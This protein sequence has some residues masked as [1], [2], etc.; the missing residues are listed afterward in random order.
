MQTRT[1]RRRVVTL[2]LASAVGGA[3]PALADDK[4]LLKQGSAPPNVMIIMANTV[5]MQYL[6]YTQGTT[7][8]VPSDG[9]YQGSSASR[10]GIAKGAVNPVVQTN[11]DRF[12]VV[13]SG[14]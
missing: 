14:C 7:P 1:A 11:I 3:F 6:P 13:L 5:S 2:L 10:F 9:Q 4:D 8:N 12:N